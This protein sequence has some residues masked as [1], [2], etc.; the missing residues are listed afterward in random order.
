M[1][2]NLRMILT[3]LN[4]LIIPSSGNT[5]LRNFRQGKIPQIG[6][7]VL[8]RFW[9]SIRNDYLVSD[10]DYSLTTT[11]MNN[12]FDIILLFIL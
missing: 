2:V 10:I 9:L 6:T 11:W 12:W 5:C 7:Q 1:K 8:R 3:L 4:T